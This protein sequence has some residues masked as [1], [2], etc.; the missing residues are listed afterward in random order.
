MDIWT[1][2]ESGD[3][4]FYTTAH[5]TK[6]GCLIEA[7]GTLIEVL[8]IPT[9]SQ[10]EFDK[11]KNDDPFS[12]KDGIPPLIGWREMDTDHLAALF[13]CLETQTWDG[14]YYRCEMQQVTLKP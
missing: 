8:R 11:W 9:D 6:K 10:K 12:E 5:L 13:D 14:D 7:I 4:G 1:F 3:D 2:T